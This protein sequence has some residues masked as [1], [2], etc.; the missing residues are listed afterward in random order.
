MKKEQSHVPDFQYHHSLRISHRNKLKMDVFSDEQLESMGLKQ[1]RRDI[2]EII[3]FSN[4]TRKAALHVAIRA[5]NVPGRPAVDSMWRFAQGTPVN[6][7][8]RCNMGICI[9]NL[10]A[11]VPG[12]RANGTVK[13]LPVQSYLCHK[14]MGVWTKKYLTSSEG[15]HKHNQH[16]KQASDISN[17]AIE[18]Y[19]E[20]VPVV[21][22]DATSSYKDV[23]LNRYLAN[24]STFTVR[25]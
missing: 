24:N 7:A 14:E 25:F 11:V 15:N 3:S 22:W 1:H 2:D 23:Y 9:I 16:L 21:V 6:S 18:K 8:T 20:Y 17:Y 12:G 10:S 19:N 13:N 5:Q 4:W